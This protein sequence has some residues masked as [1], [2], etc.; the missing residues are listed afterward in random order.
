M[1]EALTR[2]G[3][4]VHVVTY[5]LGDETQTIPYSMHR[6]AT[7]YKRLDPNPGPSLVKLLYLDPLLCA[8]IRKLLASDRFD[9]VHA[10]HYEGLIASLCARRLSTQ[11]PLI[12]DAHT[13]L[14]SEL[15]QYR[16]GLPRAFTASLGR[17]LDRRI[18][19]RADHI[20]A[21]TERIRKWFST[22]TPITADRIS[23]IANGV[24][25]D[26]FS[27]EARADRRRTSGPHIVFAGNLAE[28]QGIDLLLRAFVR[29]L[30]ERN[31]A[32]LSLLTGSNPVDVISQVDELGIRASVSFL[33]PDY[34]SLPSCLA[35]A[36]VLVNPRIDCDGIPQKLL[37]YMAAGRPIVSFE[38]SAWL[39]EHE[40][41]ALIVPDGDIQS[42]ANAALRLL[43]EPALGQSLGRAAQNRVIAGYGWEKVAERVESVYECTIGPRA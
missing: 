20:I 33:D 6:I 16:T 18:P 31:D 3:H 11:I 2:R 10:H 34:A 39:L 26:H 36:D 4:D 21:V 14:E 23:V 30:A 41:E 9:L 27:A 40:T 1:A 24:E 13:L 38:S 17:T 7:G 37:N 12:Y 19:P 22:V 5:P 43:R 15:P 25:H 35:A 8:R 42:F 28:Y 29:M 32:H